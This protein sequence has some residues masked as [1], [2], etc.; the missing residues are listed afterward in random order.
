MK[1][2][3][4]TLGYCDTANPCQMAAPAG[5]AGAASRTTGTNGRWCRKATKGPMRE[6]FGPYLALEG[7]ADS[8]IAR[9]SGNREK[10]KK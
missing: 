9:L 7:R 3:Y 8:E 10:T 4:D 5:R 2:V 6:D 1:A